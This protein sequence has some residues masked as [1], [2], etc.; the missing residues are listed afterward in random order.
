MWQVLC[1]QKHEQ[2][3][4][5]RVHRYSVR[6]LETYKEFV[7]DCSLVSQE[8]IFVVFRV[9][10]QIYQIVEYI[11]DE[12]RSTFGYMSRDEIAEGLGVPTV[13]L[14]TDMI[15]YLEQT[16]DDCHIID[17]EFGGLFDEFYSMSIDG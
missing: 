17:V 15:S 1:G 11:A 6:H 8:N 14:D 13:N 7:H 16:L 4:E 2:G 3:T 12:V 10:D 9:P 5:W